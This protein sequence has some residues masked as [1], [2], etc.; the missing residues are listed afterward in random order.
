M[1]GLDVGQIVEL[2]S[3]TEAVRHHNCFCP[4]GPNRRQQL[5][6]GDRDRD[7]IVAL[8]HAEVTCKTA[9][10]AEPVDGSAGPLKQA[11]I[12][13]ETKDCVLV[14]V[15]LDDQRLAGQVGQLKILDLVE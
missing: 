4:S 1:N 11:H 7:F 2:G 12:G 15:R 5:L 8:F 10:S 3:A 13:L 6:F 14:A 9:A